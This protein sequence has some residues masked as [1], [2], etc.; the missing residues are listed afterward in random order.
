M[1]TKNL[2]IKKEKLVSELVDQVKAFEALQ[3]TFETPE[4]MQALEDQKRKPGRPFG[5]KKAKP[6]FENKLFIGI[7]QAGNLY[8][9]I[10][11]IEVPK[12]EA[13]I[14]ILFFKCGACYVDGFNMSVPKRISNLQ[15][16]KRNDSNPVHKH[17]ACCEGCGL[18][19]YYTNL[20][21]YHEHQS[22]STL[23]SEVAKQVQY[24]KQNGSYPT[25]INE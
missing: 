7:N 22:L 11:Q 3:E 21:T 8:H 6:H 18:V 2:E 19:K 25:M 15:T 4:W 13:H 16:M 10:K 12:A 5:T 1:E 20:Q 24:Y 14:T 9:E 17:L 23:R